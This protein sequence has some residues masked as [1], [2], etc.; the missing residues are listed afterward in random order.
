MSVI[1]LLGPAQSSPGHR[2]VFQGPNDAPDAACAPCKLKS[3]CFNL[4]AGESYEVKTVR[5]KTHPCFLHEGGTV[6]VVEVDRAQHDVILPARGPTEGGTYTYPTR[7]CEF[8]GCQ[9]WQQC[10]GAPLRPGKNY[11]I[12]QVGEVIPCPLGYALRRTKARP[13]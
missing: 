6:R 7:E 3:A 8:R 1:T 5:E 9:F 11:H 13:A 10:V 2:F 12:I 4:E